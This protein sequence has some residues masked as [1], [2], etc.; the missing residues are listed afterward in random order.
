M[1]ND[2]FEKRMEFL[3]KSYERVPSSFDPEAVFNKIDQEKEPKSVHQKPKN[4]GG[5]KQKLTVW[6]AGIASVFI[7]TLIGTVFIYDQ[8]QNSEEQ[9]I[10]STVTDEYIEELKRKYEV[11]K[12]KRRKMLKLD[13]EH[14]DKYL[15]Y[16]YISM[17]D[18][19]GYINSIKQHDN[20]AQLADETYQQAIDELKTPAEMI[21]DLKSNPLTDNQEASIEF[22]NAYRGKVQ[23]LVAIYDQILAQ[24][25]EAIDAYEVDASA[26][27][28]EVMMVSTNSFPE[29][30]QNIINTMKEQ[31]IKLETGKYSGE[32]KANYY[33]SR[34]T[35]T[36]TAKLHNDT[37]AYVRMIADEPYM[38]AGILEYSIAETTG[39]VMTMENTLMK[40]EEDSS[41]YP[42]LETYFVTLFN[43]IVKG[44]KSAKL[45]NA[46]GVLLPEYQ[47]AWT[48]LS[49]NYEA[50]PLSY[51]MQPI[52][53]EMRA[54]GWRTSERWNRLS[55]ESVSEA[56]VLYRE[57]VLEEYM[58]GEQPVFE[59]ETV[60]LPNSSFDKE[61]KALYTAYKKS[62]D[63]ELLEDVSA[64]YV[65]GVFDYAN[66]MEDPETMFYLANRDSM[67]Q[68]YDENYDGVYSKMNEKD[69][70]E[71]Y[72]AKWTK[73][74]S[75]FRNATSL[76]FSGASQRF[77][78]SL[79]ST[80]GINDENGMTRTISMIYGDQ[81]V[82]EVMDVYHQR[83]PSY[84]M[85][86]E[87]EI[88]DSIKSYAKEVYG[89]FRKD[90]NHAELFG[91]QALTIMGIYFHAGA[92]KDYETQYE[93]F[94]KGKGLMEKEKFLKDAAN[95]FE[96]YSED[97]YLTMSFQGLEQDSDGNW[98]GVATLTVNTDL[99]PDLPAKREFHMF[100]TEDGWRVKF[101]P[102]K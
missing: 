37:Y 22:I 71:K 16:N 6:A 56:L 26:D 78:H 67:A 75:Q 79:V 50:T 42:V 17:L 70:L 92:Q 97:M 1:S 57:G 100:W 34:A 64:I 47:E 59:E 95:Y 46:D 98:P 91:Q 49:L 61:V 45:F 27:K 7:L 66:E 13:E 31:S 81:D 55:Y 21:E 93:L 10:E 87:M 30:L 99:Y 44:S 14:Y 9:N 96:P 77:E 19:D 52:V 4:N 82:W 39:M 35:E 53:K 24:H 36:L 54:S 32:V 20:G 18:H 102:F 60:M 2:H 41:L 85:A 73:S 58:Y 43:E 72:K 65:A 90:Y 12:E 94:Y 38:Y 40:A 101:Q 25:K 11:E 8:K 51:I 3:K 89:Y 83:I 63:K 62:Y 86:P 28:A 29:Q 80:V 33:M 68:M 84:D 5:F 15:Y 88:D 76:Q 23:R 69:L 48:T 74:L